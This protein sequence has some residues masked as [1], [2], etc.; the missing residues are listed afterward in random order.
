MKTTL[1]ATIA[2]LASAALLGGGFLCWTLVS[3]PRE[4]SSSAPERERTVLEGLPQPVDRVVRSP[5]R[6]GPPKG[7]SPS[8]GDPVF[9]LRIP[10]IQLNTVVVE[11]VR[12]QDLVSGPGHYPSCREGFELPLCSHHEE[13]LPGEKGRV[14][15][16]GHRTTYGAP[17]WD[18]DAL[19]RGDAVIVQTEWGRF[20][21][22][23]T[24]QKIID[25][26]ESG[27][28]VK[29][30]KKAEIMFTTCHPRFSAAQRLLVFAE[31]KAT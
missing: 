26:A 10:K 5:K 27:S 31:L 20:V 3:G 6:V 14:I 7:F 21:Y 23:V 15:V 24:R 25:A 9:R 28:V 1:R 29:K 13:V 2:V 17:F 19:A 11:G 22:R 4:A 12:P 30:G 16:S 18:M 8:P